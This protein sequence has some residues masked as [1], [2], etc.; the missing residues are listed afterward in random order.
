MFNFCKPGV[1]L[2]QTLQHQHLGRHNKKKDQNALN[3]TK[4][5]FL[6]LNFA[7]GSGKKRKKET[8]KTGTTIS[9]SPTVGNSIKKEKRS[10]ILRVQDSN[11]NSATGQLTLFTADGNS[12]N[13]R[14]STV[15]RPTV[16]AV[17]QPIFGTELPA[18]YKLS[19]SC[20]Y[21]GHQ[22]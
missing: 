16:S 18:S 19:R 9:K 22:R 6:K 7:H 20:F 1:G 5:I 11:G 14:V 15:Q 17:G 4:Q 3:L 2:W 8:R 13:I 12:D 21:L 10:F